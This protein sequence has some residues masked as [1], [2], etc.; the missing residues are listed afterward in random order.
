MSPAEKHNQLASEFVLKVVRETKTPGDLMVVVESA[1]A[2]AMM[3]LHRLHGVSPAACVEMVE[4]A[5]QQ[6]TERFA[7]REWKR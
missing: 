4:L 7:A 2:A 1:V 5:I 3:S 6:A